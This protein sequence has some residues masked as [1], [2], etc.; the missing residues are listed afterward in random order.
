[1]NYEKKRST[2][3]SLLIE[4]LSELQTKVMYS[5]KQSDRN[6]SKTDILHE[7]TTFQKMFRQVLS[8]ITVVRNEYGWVEVT[9]LR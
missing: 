4:G 6:K 5:M 8:K 2:V 1:M 7:P 3:F 9:E